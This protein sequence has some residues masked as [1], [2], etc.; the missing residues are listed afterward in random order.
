LGGIKDFL[1]INQTRSKSGALLLTML[2]FTIP[3]GDERL[4]K[5]GPKSAVQDGDGQIDEA[6]RKQ[7]LRRSRFRC[8]ARGAK[9]R[10]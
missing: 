3:R 1:R 5:G 6:C 9:L 7:K 2:D 4:T 8:C 10:T